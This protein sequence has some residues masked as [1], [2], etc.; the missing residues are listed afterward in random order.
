MIMG[1]TVFAIFMTYSVN[2]RYVGT[3]RQPREL[4]WRPY[5]SHVRVLE[6]I[7]NS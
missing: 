2:N 5:S 7:K 4:K 1:I 6:R 3:N